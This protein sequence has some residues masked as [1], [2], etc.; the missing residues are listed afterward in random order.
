MGHRW[1]CRASLWIVAAAVPGLLGIDV[2]AAEPAPAVTAMPTTM[3]SPLSWPAIEPQVPDTTAAADGALSV[4]DDAADALPERA[5]RSAAEV[6]TPQYELINMR[7]AVTEV[8]QNADGTRTALIHG[9]RIHY[10]QDGSAAWEKIDNTLVADRGRPGWLRNAANGWT[11]RF[12]SV[13][14]HGSGGVELVT[15]AGPVRLAPELPAGRPSIAPVVGTGDNAN[16]VT[17]PDVWPGVDVR[18]TVSNGH[19]AQDIVIRRTGHSGF[20]FVV[21]GL[22]LV[23]SA[24]AAHGGRAEVTGAHRD[25]VTLSPIEVVDGSGLMADAAA[26]DMVLATPATSEGV[27]DT[28]VSGAPQRMTL[29]VD[30]AWLATEG[31]KDDAP[32]VI[33]STLV[34]LDGSYHS[35]Y[36]SDGTVYSQDG[37]RIGNSQGGAGGADS[38][39]R[40]AAAF[41]YWSSLTGRQLVYAGLQLGVSTGSA[42]APQPVSVWWACS[43]DYSGSICGGDTTRR[44][45]TGSLGGP[46]TGAELDVTD[47]VGAWHYLGVQAG[48]FG[49]RGAET[50]GTFTYKRLHPP[51][52][53]LNVNRAPSTPALVAPADGSL[54]IT[55][56][57]P[58]LRWSAVT[59]PDGDTV[60]YT[61]M[62]ATGLDGESGMVAT[63]PEGT[64]TSWT[65]PAGVLRDGVTY[66]WKVYAND[67]HA[68][69]PSAVRRLTVDRR[70]GNARM[71]PTDNYGGVTA[72]L[73]NGNASLTVAGPTL[74]TLGGGI[75]VRFA[76]NS[77]ATRGGL[78]G[79]YRSD[80][81]GDNVIESSDPLVLVRTDPQISFDWRETTTGSGSPS[82]AVP[83]DHFTVRWSGSVALPAGSWQLGVR[84]DDGIRVWVDGVLVVDQWLI[85]TIPPAP[86]FAPSGTAGGVHQVKVEYF[87]STGAAQVELWAR[88][89]AN[90]ANQFVVPAAWLSAQP[91]PLPPGWSLDADQRSYVRAE[92]TDGSVTLYAPDGSATSFAATAFGLAYRPPPGID[93][94][95]VVNGDGTVTVHAMDGYTYLFRADGGLAKRTRALDDG[96]SA[97]TTA[98]YDSAGRVT[99]LRDP[100]SG[101][102][103]VLTYA[104]DASCPT[105]P[106]LLVDG[107][108]GAPAGMLCRMA[109]WDGTSTELY[110]RNGLLAFIRNPG[111]AYWGFGY[112]TDGRI[113]QYQEPA[114][115]DAAYSG[116]RMDWT[117]LATEIGYD[118]SGRVATITEP[119]ALA[120]AARPSRSY[121]YAPTMNGYG[122]LTGGTATVT[123]AGIS[124]VSRTV[125]YDARG[126]LTRNTDVLNRST[127]TSWNSDDLV[128]STQTPDGLRTTTSYDPFDQ[129]TDGWGPAPASMFNPDGTGKAGVPHTVTGYDQGYDGLAVTWWPNASLTGSPT[130]HDHDAGSLDSNWGTGSPAS[131]IPADNFSGRYTGHIAFPTAGTYTL[132]FVRDNKLAVFLDDAVHL[133]EWTNTTGTNDITVTTTAANTA[134]RLRIDFA[135]TTGSAVL[136]ML[137]KAPGSS[138]FVAVPGASLHTGYSLETTT[139]APDGQTTSTSYTDSTAGLGAEHAVPVARTTDPGGAGLTE[140]VTLEPAGTGHRRPVARTLPSGAGSTTTTAYYGDAETRDN[141]CTAGADPANQAGQAKLRTAADPDGTGAQAPIVTEN[142]Y[143]AAGRVVAT[144]VGAEAWTCTTYDARGRTVKVAYPAFGGQ[145]ARSVDYDYTVDPDGAGPAPTSPLVTSIADGTGTIVAEVDLLGRPVAYADVFGNVTTY[146]Y[147]LAG[148]QT[149]S[150]GPAG[151]ITR[152]YD[153]AGRIT[154]VLRNGLVLA[155]GLSYDSGDRLTAVSYPSGSG[156][157]GN[158]STGTFTYDSA[159]RAASMTWRAPSGALIT[160]DAVSRDPAGKV[161]GQV[162]DGIDHHAGNDF[163]YDAIGRLTEAWVPGAHYE[164]EFFDNGYCAAPTSHRNGNRTVTNVTPTGGATTS[165]AYCYDHADRL[166]LATDPAVGTVGYDGH[167]NITQ[168][169]GETHSYDAANRH[170]AT[171]TTSTTVSYLR[172][173]TDRI[174]ERKVNG[175]TTARY[176][177]TGSADAPAFTTNS[178]NAVIEVS[179]VLPGGAMLTAR[180]GGNVWSYPNIHG[181]VVATADQAGVKQGATTVYDPFGGTVSGNVPDNAAGEFDY[182]WLG[183]PQRPVEHQ[184]GLQRIVEMGA[185]QY[186]PLL[187]R[188]LEVDPVERGSA[189][190]YDYGNADPANQC[191]TSGTRSIRRYGW[192]VPSRCVLYGFWRGYPLCCLIYYCGT[193]FIWPYYYSLWWWK[194]WWCYY[195]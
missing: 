166:Y 48:T 46:G 47:L 99:G 137:W 131:G 45:A 142:V 61:A 82:P 180:P 161:V 175:S 91:R 107:T 193:I 134:K 115:V 100:V 138:T 192:Y 122:E 87:E 132:R 108:W 179:Y 126:R 18:Y 42:V 58:T 160:S 133:Y 104:P 96:N 143:D 84:A 71:A 4:P 30:A 172:D 169:F 51:V 8:W 19:V 11:V 57:T 68:W 33:D 21:E 92:V 31:A 151:S 64:A 43:S 7:D 89:A 60:R 65:V 148:R 109:Y 159:G 94:V 53:R 56:T 101:R 63:S 37:L 164:Y 50:P 76:Y 135:E 106:P 81:D 72:N 190:A 55:S 116:A 36:K 39:W 75:G 34:V 145:P 93:D 182:A 147:D 118:A 124:G 125:G 9:E 129:P 10:Q 59:D 105:Q 74:G 22:G 170:V 154:A 98:L 158:G 102:T 77:Q 52:L 1:F 32:V 25:D 144:R 174:V 80:T 27:P 162:V 49:V 153:D 114:F 171:G 128:T 176:G 141:P 3:V 97:A 130:V 83:K 177:Y 62:V 66:Y 110:Y 15:D 16:T 44:Y 150:S 194:C 178:A 6:S 2:V 13:A 95:V 185:R 123:V 40:S 17:Y 163:G 70:L 120:G 90:P 152:T 119:P 38:Y 23:K 112:D 155:N 111:D 54:A 5:R 186:S 35:S 139:V 140:R 79:E 85:G 20:A 183:G 165:T 41:G 157:G 113:I 127:T 86:L 88:D 156:N 12:G 146:G 14:A 149:G 181:D 173:A 26:P 188:F 136:R 168:I 195:R 24:P 28:G 29:S 121:G 189:N 191:D 69:A 73:V 78:L 167:G 187:G 117:E 184:P 67:G 103:V